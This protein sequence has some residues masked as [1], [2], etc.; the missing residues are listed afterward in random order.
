M[1]ALRP[2]RLTEAEE[3]PLREL[4]FFSTWAEQEAQAIPTT[5]IV[6]F[7]LAGSVW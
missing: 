2:G 3:M 5:G 1:S 4:S 7:I 6:F